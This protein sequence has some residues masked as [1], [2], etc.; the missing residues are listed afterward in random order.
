MTR[1]RIFASHDHRDLEQAINE[2]LEQH[3]CANVRFLQL[4]AD[5]DYPYAVLVAWD[6]EN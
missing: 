4:V 1:I 3:R 2:W 6:D 5:G